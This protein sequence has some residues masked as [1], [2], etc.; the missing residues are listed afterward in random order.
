MN[1]QYPDVVALFQ[2]I[3]QQDTDLKSFIID[4]EIVAIDPKT[5]STRSFQDL[6]N[7]ARKAVQLHEIFGGGVCL[8]TC[9][10]DE[11]CTKSVFTQESSYRHSNFSFVAS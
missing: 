1:P 5:G 7:R 2:H 4:A 11:G 9:H 10:H 6:S 8:W 3:L